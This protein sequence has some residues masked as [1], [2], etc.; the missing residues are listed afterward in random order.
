M[1]QS[2]F[3]VQMKERFIDCQKPR[4]KKKRVKCQ[5]VEDE[6]FFFLTIL[7]NTKHGNLVIFFSTLFSKLIRFVAQLNAGT[8]LY[9]T[10]YT[11]NPMN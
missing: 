5:N 11:V 4:K 7:S 3:L 6:L 9:D 8:C 2:D 1:A 10:Y